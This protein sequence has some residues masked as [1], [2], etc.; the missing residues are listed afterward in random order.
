MKKSNAKQPPFKVVSELPAEYFL[1]PRKVQGSRLHTHT[2]YEIEFYLTDGGS[3]MLNNEKYAIRRNGVCISVPTDLHQLHSDNGE[4]ILL[5][6]LSFMS[7]MLNKDLTDK[8]LYSAQSNVYYLSEEDGEQIRTILGFL[9]KE[10]AEKQKNDN[11]AELC[12]QSIVTL[13]LRY[14]KEQEKTEKNTV[15]LKTVQYVLEHFKEDIS[16]ESAAKEVGLNPTYL[17]HNFHKET[18][19]KFKEYLI[20][21]RINYAKKLIKANKEMITNA[22]FEAGFNSYSAFSRAFASIV[23]CSP[24]EYANRFEQ[25]PKENL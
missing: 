20:F 5:D 24:R 19:F 25:T 15:A 1:A 2:F 12:I 17:S 10:Q 16:L 7:S 21:T 3:V 4:N 8:L 6:N 13:L 18:G 14:R 9:Y 11:F 22:C 23:G